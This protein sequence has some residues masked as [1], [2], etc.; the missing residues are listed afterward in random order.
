[1]CGV[2][3]SMCNTADTIFSLPY[4]CFSQSTLSLHH[5]SSLPV[6]SIF[7]MSS[8]LPETTIRITRTWFIP[9]LRVSPAL[10]SRWLMAWL[11]FATPSGNTI[12]SRLRGVR[13]GS[14]LFGMVFL[15]MWSDILV[16]AP[17]ALSRCN[18]AY[19]IYL[20]SSLFVIQCFPCSL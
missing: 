9:I 11:R 13:V 18:T 16:S 14:A 10:S 1:M 7:F 3:S 5:S 19:P 4:V 2:F 17:C 20:L 6:C 15:S 12:S 8:G